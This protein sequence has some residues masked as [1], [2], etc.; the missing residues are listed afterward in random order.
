MRSEKPRVR[1][2]LKVSQ[3]SIYR[4]SVAPS[5]ESQDRR[6]EDLIERENEFLRQLK[7]FSQ[8]AELLR[9]D[10]LELDDVKGKLEDKAIGILTFTTSI[11][12]YRRFLD[13]RE[14]NARS[15]L[16]DP[17]DDTTALEEIVTRLEAS[18]KYLGCDVSS[19]INDDIEVGNM[20]EEMEVEA[21]EN[22]NLSR[23]MKYSV[24]RVMLDRPMKVDSVKKITFDGEEDRK[25]IDKARIELAQAALKRANDLNEL[26]DAR[27]KKLDEIYAKLE[28]MEDEADAQLDE[29]RGKFKA[30]EKMIEEL[31]DKVKERDDL[32]LSINTMNEKVGKLILE[33]A[34]LRDQKGDLSRGYNLQQ[35]RQELCDFDKQQNQSRVG[36]M[37]DRKKFAR[38][39]RHNNKKRREELKI[40]EQE[41]EQFQQ[42]CE[43]YLESIL[44]IEEESHD[45][46]VALNSKLKEAQ[47]LTEDVFNES[48]FESSCIGVSTKQ[49]MHK[50]FGIVVEHDDAV[51]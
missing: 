32:L 28:A 50:V 15:L 8:N 5:T 43:E 14:A 49:E 33:L 3:W 20:Q 4:A 41:V 22:E 51:E 39:R 25:E 10:Q 19:T 11:E 9:R 45:V 34:S 38:K 7:E 35:R 47:G 16:C 26:S 12:L 13:E 18:L 27:Q 46:E 21:L 31:R 23:R 37:E 48:T 1:R 36:K 29:C 44:A 40:T 17:V 2:A 30:K 24:L 6:L 42:Q